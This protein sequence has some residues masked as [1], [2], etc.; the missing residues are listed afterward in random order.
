MASNRKLERLLPKSDDDIRN[1][2]ETL[3]AFSSPM[4][5]AE[6]AIKTFLHDRMYRA[7]PVMKVRDNAQIIVRDLFGAYFSGDAQMPVDWGLD[8]QDASRKLDEQ[9]RARLVA[10]FLSGMTDRYAIFEH[11]RLFDATPELR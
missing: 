7:P 8:W 5:V 10:D 6:K 11:K 1:A 3:V 2:G 9:K 4:T